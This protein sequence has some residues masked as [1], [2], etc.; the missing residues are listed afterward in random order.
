LS[1][2][3]ASGKAAGLKS[4]WIGLWFGLFPHAGATDVAE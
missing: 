4:E 3:G 1:T 2:F